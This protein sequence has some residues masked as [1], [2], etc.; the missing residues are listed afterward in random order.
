MEIQTESMD[1]DSQIS[2]PW[3]QL[4]KGYARAIHQTTAV[5]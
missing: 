2:L 5:I 1:Y 3:C 4:P